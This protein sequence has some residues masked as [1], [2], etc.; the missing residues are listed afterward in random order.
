MVTRIL[1]TVSDKKEMALNNNDRLW[2]QSILKSTIIEAVKPLQE[3]VNQHHQTLYGINLN[4]GLVKSIDDM[5]SNQAMS[6][7]KM[8]KF[9]GIASGAWVGLMAAIAI[10]SKLI[11]KW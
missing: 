3:K 10:A 6:R 11:F 5:T 8:W 9:V 1:F 2:I 4:D 7:A